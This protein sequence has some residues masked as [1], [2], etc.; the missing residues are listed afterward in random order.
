MEET[1]N[2][3]ELNTRQA[4]DLID[5]IAEFASPV[6]IFSGGEPLLRK[7]IF[8]L[9]HYAGEKNLKT[10]LATNGTIIDDCIVSKIKYSSIQRVSISLDGPDPKT[11]DALRRSQ[12]AFNK[13]EKGLNMLISAGISSQ[14]NMTVTRKNCHLLEPMIHFAL[15]KRVEALHFF[16]VVPVG[17]GRM[18]DKSELFDAEDYE[19]VL[20][21]I[22][23]LE[24]RYSSKLF[25]KVTC[26]PQYYRLLQNK[27]PEVFKQ[28]PGRLHHISK[29]CLAGT[30][31]CFVS[32]S[33][34]VYPCGYLP[35][36][37]GNILKTPFK[38][39]WQSSEVFKILRDND[40]LSENCLSCTYQ[41]VC[42]GCRARAFY[43]SGGNYMAADPDCIFN[44]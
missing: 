26:A 39:I 19:Q 44:V 2:K 43:A 17:C 42:G 32:S 25:V 21:D 37:A 29:G 22:Y 27:T 28:Q 12:G 31:V 18:L 15:E 41:R 16:V 4:K 30:A 24:K 7:D 14:I 20:K 11:H 33:G 35:V 8:D 1:E 13:A 3:Y 10:A 36:I 23:C 6:F 34:D 9:A 40:S 5:D 38:E